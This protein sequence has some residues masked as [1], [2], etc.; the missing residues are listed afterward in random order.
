MGTK[1]YLVSNF[2]RDCHLILPRLPPFYRDVPVNLARP[3]STEPR[4]SYLVQTLIYLYIFFRYVADEENTLDLVVHSWHL[5]WKPGF[6]GQVSFPVKE[7]KEGELTGW[8]KLFP[9][10]G[11]KATDYGEIR[12]TINYKI[13]I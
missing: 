9:A 4:T 1:F 10:E 13:G 11:K 12:L 7:L 5:L 2:Y 6:R 3:S 8:F